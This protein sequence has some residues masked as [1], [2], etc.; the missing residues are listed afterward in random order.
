MQMK[1][2]E[3]V[4]GACYYVRLNSRLIVKRLTLG[5]RTFVYLSFH[6]IYVLFFIRIKSRPLRKLAHF[7]TLPSI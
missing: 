1:P 6:C 7:H 5:N 3:R 4:N 2:H